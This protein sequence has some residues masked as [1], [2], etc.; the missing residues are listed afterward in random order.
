MSNVSERDSQHGA[1]SSA[2]K[3]GQIRSGASAGT[4]SK[5]SMN[6]ESLQADGGDVINGPLASIPSASFATLAAGRPLDERLSMAYL[7]EAGIYIYE[8]PSGETVAAI[9]SPSQ[10]PVIKTIE[11]TIQRNLALEIAS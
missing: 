7:R 9:A 6:G 2:P 4:T 11:W 1:R 10:L 3:V 8:S 5:K